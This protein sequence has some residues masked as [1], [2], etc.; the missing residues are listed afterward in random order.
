[1]PDID[2][3]DH[4][5]SA[6]ESADTTADRRGTVVT[7]LLG[8]VIGGAI[9][10][11]VVWF[12]TDDAD[13][14]PAASVPST[15]AVAIPDPVDLVVA[16]G[17]SRNEDHALTGELRQ[18][19]RDPLPVRRAILGDR[20]ID[21][22]G[23]TAAVTEN[24]ETQQCERSEGQWLCAPPLPAIEPEIDVRGFASLL[25]TESPP[26]SVFAVTTEPPADLASI[27]DLGPTTCWSMVSADRRDRARFGAE[28]T[29]CFHDQ[30]GALVGRITET[31]SGVDRFVATELRGQV[32]IAD[33]EPSR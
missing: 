24:G 15:V 30:V 7:V 12:A 23:T 18:G 28:T 26:Y 14:A 5:P 3:A 6:T 20:A 33:V 25:L 17:R 19:D 9:A 21:E 22:A 13:E 10:A 2:L 4:T 8:V 11:A 1:M 16:Y 27:V 29:L 31:S 32:T